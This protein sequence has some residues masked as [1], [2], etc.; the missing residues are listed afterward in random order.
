MIR[1]SKSDPLVVCTNDTETG[2]NIIAG[3]GELH[4]QVCLKD[5]CEEFAQIEIIKSDPIVAYRETVRQKS[6]TVMAKSNNNH[7]RL[8][9]YA[10]PLSEELT[11]AVENGDIPF[12]D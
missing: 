5:L 9:C 4:V 6:R 12:R 3:S 2:E 8:Y 10:E 1:L 11:K 7:N